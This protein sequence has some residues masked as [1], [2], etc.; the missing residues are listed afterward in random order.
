M[1]V[2]LHTF[3]SLCV[4]SG[5]LVYSMSLAAA[6][7][8]TEEMASLCMSCIVMHENSEQYGLFNFYIINKVIIIILHKN[9]N[10][11]RNDFDSKNNLKIEE[12]GSSQ[13]W[14]LITLELNDFSF[15]LVLIQV[16]KETETESPCL[17]SESIHESRQPMRSDSKFYFINKIK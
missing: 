10:Q 9:L 1:P 6:W 4:S 16:P 13:V 8:R 12:T 2:R 3:H 14:K 11:P 17:E 15:E 7:L 5:S